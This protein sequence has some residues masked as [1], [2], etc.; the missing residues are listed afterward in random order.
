M[1][2][3]CTLLKAKGSNVMNRHGL[4]N[5]GHISSNFPRF[6]CSSQ[7]PQCKIYTTIQTF[8]VGKIL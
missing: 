3:Y 8:E 5:P 4:S 1:E 6:F 2:G 7:I